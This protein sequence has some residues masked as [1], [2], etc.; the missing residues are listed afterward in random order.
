MQWDREVWCNGRYYTRECLYAHINDPGV[1]K[2]KDVEGGRG[3]IFR[4]EALL[5]G[6]RG[7]DVASQRRQALSLLSV[8]TQL[9]NW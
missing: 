1:E 5:K 8:G 9:G 7:W 3:N 6:K 4:S 2:A